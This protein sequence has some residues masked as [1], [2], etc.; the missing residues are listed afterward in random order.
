MNKTEIRLMKRELLWTKV[1]ACALGAVAVI[2]AVKAHSRARSA[3]ARAEHVRRLIPAYPP[4]GGVH[5]GGG[6]HP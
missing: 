2:F 3:E 4:G 6:G 1:A 5:P